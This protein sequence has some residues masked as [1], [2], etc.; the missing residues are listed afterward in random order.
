MTDPRTDDPRTGLSEAEARARLARHG[1]NTL[2]EPRAPSLA[3]LFLRQFLSPLIYILL[4]AAVVSVGLGDTR[5]ALFILAVLLING[6]IG[7]IQEHS[8][9]RAAAALRELQHPHATVVRD[10]EPRRIDARDLVPGDLVLLE[11]GAGVPAD[12]RLVACT[13]LECDESLLTGESRPVRKTAHP[14]ADDPDAGCAFAGTMVTRGRARGVVIAT[15]TATRIGRIAQEIARRPSVRAPLLIRLERFSR[16]IAVAVGVAVLVVAAIGLWRGLPLVDLFMMA[17]S[18]AVSAIPEGLPVAISV[19]LAIAIRRMARVNVI[20]RRMAAVEA[21]GSCTMIATDKTGTLTLNRLAVTDILLPDGTAARLTP[22]AGPGRLPALHDRPPG[23]EPLLRTAV[24]ANE[25]RLTHDGERGWQGHGDTVDVALLMAAQAAGAGPGPEHALPR[26]GHIPYEPDLRYGASFH[27]DGDGIGVFVKGAPEVLIAMCDRML[28]EGQA[29]PIDRARLAAQQR[30][31]AGRGLRVLAFAS[32]LI[33]ATPDRDYGP[34]HLDGLVFLG[35]A[36]MQDP[37][38]PEVPAAIAD[39][40]RAGVAVVMVTGDDPATALVIAR[41]AGLDATSDQVVTGPDLRAAEA[42]GEAAIDRLTRRARV[43]ARVDP[44]QKLAIVRSLARNG[45][46][47]AVT[48]DGVNDAPALRH[49][50]VGVA[51]GQGGTDVARQSA[52]IVVTDDNFASI[53]HGIR[54]GRVAYANIRKV[55][56]MQVATGAAEVALFLLAMPLGLPLPMVAVQLLW[57]NLVTNGI[58]DVALAT[59][60]AEGDEL[61]RPPRRPDEPLVD[62]AMLVRIGWSVLVMGG[63]GALL[64]AW[65]LA[66]GR[67]EPEARNLLLLLFVLFENFLTLSSRSETRPLWHGFGS[68]PLLLAGVGGAQGLHVAAM[69]LPLLAD[70]LAIAPV[71]LREWASLLGL[72]AILPVVLEIGKWRAR[73]QAGRAG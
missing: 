39:C 49:A 48:G 71:S 20:V 53:V 34:D 38:R 3:G 8:A 41:Q 27:R 43:F 28:V 69:Y 24:L 14:P 61:A 57:L 68:N 7:T 21:L 25:G 60:P 11:A 40:R 73:R 12:L 19:A 29:V 56:F 1:P 17:V 45:H 50:H 15:G 16:M 32:G 46:F 62:R 4:A 31:L 30:A 66:H 52:D 64:F 35:L 65:L 2:P 23:L 70:T 44:T 42:E 5:D 26:L 54:E 59:E 18:L 67:A 51:M 47:V 22:P 63:G 55:V 10:G 9:S 13:G 37:L 33:E 36:G 6:V 72:A 58:Q